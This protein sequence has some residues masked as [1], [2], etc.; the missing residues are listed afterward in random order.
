M[1][2]VCSQQQGL[3]SGHRVRPKYN[4]CPH[5]RGLHLGP[6]SEA[7]SLAK[8]NNSE[9][10]GKL[11]TKDSYLEDDKVAGPSQ[12]P[13]KKK[14]LQYLV[15][16]KTSFFP[17]R[18]AIKERGGHLKFLYKLQLCPKLKKKMYIITL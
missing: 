5:P 3:Q 9:L 12:R 7:V 15:E 8:H 6:D 11:K 4:L 2:K 10:S 14:W 18:Y 17:P 16:G 13:F 1:H